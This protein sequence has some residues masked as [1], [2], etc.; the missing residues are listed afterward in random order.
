[1]GGPNARVLELSQSMVSIGRQLSQLIPGAFDEIR[2]IN[3][4]IGKIQQKAVKQA[5]PA[6]PMAP[7]V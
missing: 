1:M 3:D 7:P 6:E 5:G 2:Q 4:L